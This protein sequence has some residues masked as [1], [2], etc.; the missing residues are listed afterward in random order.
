MI[1]DLNVLIIL[2]GENIAQM[3]KAWSKWNNILLKYEV[4]LENLSGSNAR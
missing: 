3:H 4:S 1:H 2:A